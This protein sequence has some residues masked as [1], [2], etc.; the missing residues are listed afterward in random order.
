MVSGSASDENSLKSVSIK[1]V[2]ANSATAQNSISVDV[3]SNSVTFQKDYYLYDIHI[4]TGIYYIVVTAS[5]G[6][7]D[8]RVYRK[9]QI[10][11]VPDRRRGVYV[12]TTPSSVQTEVNYVD[13]VFNSSLRYSYSGAYVSSAVSSYHQKFFVATSS[14]SSGA[15]R[16][17]DIA[18]G[19]QLWSESQPNSSA[20]YFM[21]LMSDE[22]YLYC[23]YYDEYIQKYNYN[24]YR[25]KAYASA[26]SNYPELVVKY[27][28]YFVSEQKSKSSNPTNI[29]VFYN[30]GALKQQKDVG[31]D[32]VSILEKDASNLFVLG[33]NG[34]QGELKI[35][36]FTN[37]FFW[38][39][40]TL[41][42]G[43]VIDAIRID[44]STIL[45][46]H[47]NGTIYKYQYSSTG[48]TPYI[49]GVFASKLGYD[50]VNNQLLV[51]SAK[52]LV[53]YNY[54]ITPSVI[55]T[56]TFT[57]T[58]QNIHILYNK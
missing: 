27:Y 10:T 39:P 29:S 51:A 52:D 41:S 2:D 47:E 4:E 31:M 45:I 21:N 36:D 44:N 54:S 7:S 48:L 37:N 25:E 24:S 8:T 55:H 14:T 42:A 40:T 6:V 33:N 20:N 3:S 32:V 38:A 57:D 43:K 46:A 5:D 11:E 12:I 53:Y 16:V 50:G 19:N 49:T 22:Q 17:I 13:S 56:T 18:S 9:I 1:L 26:S 30:T 34:T 23:S 35:Y 58:I 15:L 28:D